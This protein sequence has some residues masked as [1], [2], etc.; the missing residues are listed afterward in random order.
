VEVV[1][2]LD[3]H[4]CSLLA[5]AFK[6]GHAFLEDMVSN[7]AK[8]TAGALLPHEISASICHNEDNGILS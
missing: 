7:K 3:C 2:S 5:V 4:C 6:Y 1:C 8:I